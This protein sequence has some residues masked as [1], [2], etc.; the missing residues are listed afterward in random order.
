MRFVRIVRMST[1]Q[2]TAAVREGRVGGVIRRAL[3]T[4][5]PEAASVGPMDGVRTGV[6]VIDRDA[7]SRIPAISEPVFQSRG[8]G[9]TSC[10]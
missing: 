2:G 7:A 3:E 9:S 1:E 4:L 8:H 6:P 10:R 5:R